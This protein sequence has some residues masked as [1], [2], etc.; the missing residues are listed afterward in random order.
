MDAMRR[1][2]PQVPS[3][4]ERLYLFSYEFQ[5]SRWSLEIPAKSAAEAQF[6]LDRM[7]AAKYDGE[8]HLSVHIPT[9]LVGRLF[10]WLEKVA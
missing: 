10:A 5:G 7:A 4:R 9:G 8:V 2:M 6:R 1:N 3:D